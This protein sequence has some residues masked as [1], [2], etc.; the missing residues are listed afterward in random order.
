MSSFARLCELMK[1]SGV[2]MRL[3]DNSEMRMEL[4][5]RSEDGAYPPV[6]NFATWTHDH[7]LWRPGAN[8]AADLCVFHVDGSRLMVALV[9]RANEP[10][11]G[12]WAFPGGF[13][14]SA[15]EDGAFEWGAEKAKEAALRRFAEETLSHDAPVDVKFVGKFDALERDP[16]NSESRWVEEWL[17]CAK[18]DRL[19]ELAAG[20]AVR[21]AAWI[22]VQDA[23]SGRV[24]L[25][26]DHQ[27]LLRSALRTA[28][29]A[30]FGGEPAWL[31]GSTSLAFGSG[32]RQ[33]ATK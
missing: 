21:S 9:E 32:K 25:A 29:L 15:A 20:D 2:A 14:S 1:G 26:F 10:C 30:E 28:G 12:Q 23:L 13:V 19:E 5:W 8:P 7:M 17:F 16:R 27:D 6:E 24:R 11:A 18:L 3:Y 4:A 31:A 33:T 22:D